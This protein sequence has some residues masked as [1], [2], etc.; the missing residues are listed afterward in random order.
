MSPNV[1]ADLARPVAALMEQETDV[2]VRHY[3]DGYH[4]L[5]GRVNGFAVPEVRLLNLEG[6]GLLSEYRS[7]PDSTN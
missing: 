6:V 4:M 5:G 7:S 3:G 1:P 2:Q